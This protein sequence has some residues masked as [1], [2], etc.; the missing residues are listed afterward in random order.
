VDW[1]YRFI[2]FHDKRHPKDMGGREIG[3]FLSHLAS[4]G[5]VAAST[6]NQALSGI[7]FLY[8]HVLKRDPGEFGDVVRAKKPKR[9]PVVL[10]P[11]EVERILAQVAG[12]V[13]LMLVLMYGTGMR[14]LEVLRLRVKDVDFENSCICVRDGK[15]RKD[16]VVPLP[17]NTVEALR[18]QLKRVKDLHERDLADGYG[19]AY[20]PNALERKYPNA[21]REWGWQYVFPSKKLSV[22]PRSGRTQR[23][24][25]YE[26]AL[27]TS[28]RTA[29]RK[30]GIPKPVHAHTFRHSFASHMLAAGA[31]IRTVQE[32]LGHQDVR[33]TMVYTHIL[34]NGSLGVVT[35]DQRI[36]VGVIE[37]GKQSPR[38]TE[39]RG[40]RASASS[41][42][43]RAA[44]EHAAQA[45]NEARQPAA[46]RMAVRLERR[47]NRVRK[48][49][50]AAVAPFLRDL[51]RPA[52]VMRP[53]RHAG[54]PSH[55]QP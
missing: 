13:K 53:G 8:R 20:L 30:A 2:I 23:H 50:G 49:I 46:V 27:Q 38:N 22:D 47:I 36:D 6:Q 40:A 10:S 26:S 28:I 17:R 32:L 11:K 37:P 55:R 41:S 1:V 4:D 15:G 42:A 52:A 34:K 45:E 51:F 18:V 7:L 3:E 35:P 24:H 44:K 25:A 43:P 39:A 16:R 54:R 33:T 48:H 14:I 31:D 12:T 9:L 21:N 19:T 29:T 5:K